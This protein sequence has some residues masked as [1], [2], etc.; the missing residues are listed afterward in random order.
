MSRNRRERFDRVFGGTSPVLGM[1]HLQA[2]PGSPG[3][4]GSL[5]A[6]IE[7][8]LRDVAT[9]VDGGVDALIVENLHDAPYYPETTE[10]ETVAAMAVCAKEVVRQ[11]GVPVGINVLRNSWKAS[12]GVAAA[13]GADF[14]RL[15]ILTDAMVT[16]QGIINGAAHLVTRY[17]KAIGAD[18]VLIMADLLTKHAAPLVERPVPVIAGDMLDRGGA[19]AIILAGDDSSM[20]PSL[21]RVEVIKEAFPDAP[22]VLGSGMTAAVG[23][24]YARVADGAV[25]GYGS[26]EESDMARPVSAEL[27]EAFVRVWGDGRSSR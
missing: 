16:D 6:V 26:K 7:H 14:I 2:L 8:A 15:N 23:E 21:S 11:A 1:I 25:F 24:E 12:L 9:M 10:P 19:D 5:D 20:P 22:V 13:S 17:R 4:A 27:T 18:D 3:F